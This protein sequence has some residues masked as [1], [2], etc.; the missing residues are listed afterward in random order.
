MRIDGRAQPEAEGQRLRDMALE[1]WINVRGDV[2]VKAI[3]MDGFPDVGNK[4]PF[5]CSY[6]LVMHEQASLSSQRMNSNFAINAIIRTFNHPGLDE[7]EVRGPVLIL[8]IKDGTVLDMHEE[9]MGLIEVIVARSVLHEHQKRVELELIR[10][11]QFIQKL[12]TKNDERAILEIIQFLPISCKVLS[13]AIRQD[14]TS[15]SQYTVHPTT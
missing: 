12:V 15:P 7:W 8:K 3:F 2:P 13:R 11:P 14:H 1:E 4:Y 6:A 9:D 5:P 10:S